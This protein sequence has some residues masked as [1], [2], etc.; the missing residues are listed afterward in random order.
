MISVLVPSAASD[1]DAQLQRLTAAGTVR[2]FDPIVVDFIDAIS[3]SVLL[4]L[5]MRRIP[6]M[7]AVAHWMR[8]AHVLELRA[9]FEA[10]RGQRIWLGRGT[11]LHFAPANVDSIFL[12]SWFLSMLIGN[13]NI[14]R[15][16]QRRGEQVGL[17][18]DKINAALEQEKFA[19]IRDRSLVLA[20]DYDDSLTAR[21]SQACQVRVLWG[22]DE[23]VRRLRSVPMNPL[24]SEIVFPNRFSLAVLSAES[25][26]Q[27]T[28]EQMDQLAQRFCNDAYW[29]DQ[30][31]CSSP[32]LVVWIGD[33][34]R[35]ESAQ[36]F[37]WPRIEEELTRRAVQYPEVVGMNKL[38]T[39]YVSAGNSLVDHIE[40]NPTGLVSRAHLSSQ[41][42]PG[43]RSLE[44]GGGFFFERKCPDLSRLAPL[45]TERDQT[46]S[47][48]GFDHKQLRAFAHSLPTR[49]VDR[50][51]PLGT[52]L[53]FST[54]WDGSDLLQSFSR[55]VDLQ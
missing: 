23:S 1:H 27:S 22:G 10:R 7:A 11:A 12:Y 49:A 30:M 29:F 3:K 28:P 53:N 41:A 45:L 4:D 38:V 14:V 25:I 33:S 37:F 31:A 54:I 36:K 20:Y 15:L 26:I 34:H 16:S 48:F 17:L 13:A 42:G 52:A 8:K 50:I 5:V 32:R 47:Y 39:A 18:L 19:P 51:V 44:C 6:E 40:H 35:C 21:L 9:A 46:L 43:F 55:E 24:A 2:P